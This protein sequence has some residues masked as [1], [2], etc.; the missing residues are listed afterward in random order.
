MSF[1]FKGSYILQYDVNRT[2]AKWESTQLYRSKD[3]PNSI[4]VCDSFRNKRVN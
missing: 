2:V 1:G 3:W 4:R